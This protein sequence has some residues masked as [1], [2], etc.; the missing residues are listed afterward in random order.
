VPAPPRSPNEQLQ[1][2]SRLR[3]RQAI[4]AG[5]AAILLVAAAIVQVSGPQSKVSEL[6]V[7]LILINKR[8]PLDV[9]GAVIQGFGLLALAWTLS[10]LFE[11]AR[12]RRP[13]MAPPTRAVAVAGAVVAA[14]GSVIYAAILASKAHQFATQGGQTY[15]QANQ[16]TKG[17][18]LPVLQTLDIAAQFALEIGLILIALNAMRVGLL[19]RFMGYCGMVV[20]VAGMLLIGSAPAAALQIFWVGALAYLFAGR[21]AGGD[22]PAWRT[23]RAEPWPSTQ[24]LR[25]QRMR[26]GGGAPKAK[27]APQPAP[28]P[29]VVGATASSRSRGSTPKRKRKRRR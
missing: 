10:F 6:T 17:A 21:W 20:G 13:E 19:T 16:L 22:P 29:E 14:V 7:Q 9:I 15:Q 2:E 24:E 23:G 12:A 27:P 4:I 11:A 28:S 26:A 8:F 25:D 18:S 3:P 5:L 1:R